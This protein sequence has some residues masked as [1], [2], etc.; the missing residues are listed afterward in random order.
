[1]EIIF[2]VLVILSIMISVFS[3]SKKKTAAPASKDSVS[4]KDDEFSPIRLGAH[5]IRPA[6]PSVTRSARPVRSAAATP[7]PLS[8]AEAHIKQPNIR[9]EKVPAGGSLETEYLAQGHMEGRDDI[10]NY[11]FVLEDKPHR[12]DKVSPIRMEKEQ[13]LQGFIWSQILNPRGGK[14]RRI[15]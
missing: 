7:A 1:M 15:H 12:E 3:S 10:R 5:P 8:P 4:R 9:V 14:V 2:A 11:R 13:I 6:Q